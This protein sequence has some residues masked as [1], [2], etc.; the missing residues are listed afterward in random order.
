[1]LG[2]LHNTKIV[3]IKNEDLNEM[4]TILKDSEKFN[5]EGEA[6]SKKLREKIPIVYASEKLAA[7]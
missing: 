4:L 6:L 2:L 1:M 3:R 7:L 5:E